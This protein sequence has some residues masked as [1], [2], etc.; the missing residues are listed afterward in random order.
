MTSF[1]HNGIHITNPT[2]SED[3]REVVSP[4]HYDFTI[5][6][7]GGGCTAWVKRSEDGVLVVTDDSGLS[8]NLK[9]N[10]MLGLYDGS[11]DEGSFGHCLAFADLKVGINC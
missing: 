5:E 8:H 9:D 6:S 7:T 2:L 10:I 11:E 3:G 1:M 4:S